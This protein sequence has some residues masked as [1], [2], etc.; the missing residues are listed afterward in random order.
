LL[1][2]LVGTFLRGLEMSKENGNVKKRI[3]MTRVK[4][5][6]RI[7]DTISDIEIICHNDNVV[8]VGLSIL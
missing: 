3:I 1:E 2:N 5:K 6:I 7:P 8:N 4:W